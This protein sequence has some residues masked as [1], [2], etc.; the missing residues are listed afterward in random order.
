MTALQSVSAPGATAWP[1]VGLCA[2]AIALI[3]I[4]TFLLGYAGYMFV[5]AGRDR[6]N[7]CPMDT[8]KGVS[9]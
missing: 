9:S 7:G 4:V 2:A 3:V 8:E 6:A 1:I 5:S